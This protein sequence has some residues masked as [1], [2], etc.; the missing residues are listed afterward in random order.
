MFSSIFCTISPAKTS[1]RV[2]D[3]NRIIN[4]NNTDIKDHPWQV[5]LRHPGH[6][7]FCGG[8]II[9]S[10][11]ILTAAHCVVNQRALNL[12]V[13]VG[14]TCQTDDGY[15]KIVK[16]III[17]PYYSAAEITNDIAILI[18]K[19]E[20]R[21]SDII[22]PIELPSLKL[23]L[24]TNTP[25]ITTGWGQ[26]KDGVLPEEL[27]VAELKVVAQDVCADAFQNYERP[28]NITS[29]MICAGG[30]HAVSCY[31]RKFLYSFARLLI[32]WSFNLIG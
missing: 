16:K 7:H 15:I 31:V 2:H 10:S 26:N 17:H 22:Q 3:G 30:V 6:N 20:L 19:K 14:I 18:L 25:V 5:S 13:H 8:S 9:D 12:W 23:V 11:R 32:V 4:G 24:S 28:M 29:S 1:G 27:Q 21:F